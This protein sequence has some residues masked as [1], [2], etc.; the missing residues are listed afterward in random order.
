MLPEDRFRAYAER[1]FGG[2]VEFNFDQ[3]KPDTLSF[4]LASFVL[5]IR[6]L[7]QIELKTPQGRALRL[8]VGVTAELH[9]N[10]YADEYREQHY[11]SMTFGHFLSNFYFAAETFF[12]TD[13]F[14]DIGPVVAHETSDIDLCPEPEFWG[15]SGV[16]FIEATARIE[17]GGKQRIWGSYFL[18]Y[19]MT[20]IAYYHE[21]F[22]VVSG[23]CSVKNNFG[24]GPRL[25]ET[26]YTTGSDTTNEILRS[27]EATADQSAIFMLINSIVRDADLP[28]SGN[29]VRFERRDRI[30]LALVASGLLSVSW[31]VW[32]KR[33]GLNIQTHPEPGARFVHFFVSAKQ[34]LSDCG[35]SELFEPSA[36]QAMDDLARISSRCPDLAHAMPAIATGRPRSDTIK[37]IP[38]NVIKLLEEHQFLPR[39]GH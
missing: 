32:Q 7:A 36:Q 33:S 15:Q 35:C 29:V 2:C 34:V 37:P 3:E 1:C 20:M 5:Q 39:P 17:T 6:K 8:N 24:L 13:C 21:Y 27:F 10:A 14:G 23:H 4:M 16:A 18:T 30:R 11:I 22:H 19:A 26:G 31:F 25:Q 28:T 9:G 38:S 12:R